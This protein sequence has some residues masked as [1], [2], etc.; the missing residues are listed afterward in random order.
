VGV[1]PVIVA[2]RQHSSHENGNLPK[3]SHGL[4]VLLH[5][6]HCCLRV[7]HLVMNNTKK[8]YWNVHRICILAMV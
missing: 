3:P 2:M 6:R 7:V 1:R 4:H 5:S 8:F